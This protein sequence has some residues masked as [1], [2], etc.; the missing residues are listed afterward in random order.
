VACEQDVVPAELFP[1]KL[2][3]RDYLR[4]S[5]KEHI[6]T[7]M[8][9]YVYGARMTEAEAYPGF[10]EVLEWMVSRQGYQVCII[11]H[12]TK[13]P[14]LGP[15]Y[16]LHA[17]ARSWI[18]KYSAW[19]PEQNV[20]FLPTKADKIKKINQ[21]ACDI[22]ID[23]L[24]E[25]LLDQNFPEASHRLLFDPENHHQIDENISELDSIS[26]WFALPEWLQTRS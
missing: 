14:F 26:N 12:K 4:T 18:E 24:P 7:E 6:W 22:F 5:G 13:Y 2:A 19:I 3:V 8:Q 15:Q 21:L 1:S 25:I 23:D 20:Y 17:A 9:G 16:D 11:S 10:Q